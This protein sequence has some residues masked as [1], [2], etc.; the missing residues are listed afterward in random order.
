M[1]SPILASGHPKD[2]V[3]RK[4]VAPPDVDDELAIWQAVAKS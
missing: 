2:P 1:P 3:A 4:F